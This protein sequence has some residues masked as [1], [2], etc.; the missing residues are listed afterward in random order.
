MGEISEYLKEKYMKNKG[1]NQKD[2]M[3]KQRVKNALLRSCE[4]H[5]LEP[6][7]KYTFEVLPNDL[8]YV[9]SSVMEEPIKSR[10]IITQISNTLF[11]AELQ[12]IDLGLW[13]RFMFYGNC[14]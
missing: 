4:E 5:V 12:E 1:S 3:N 7:D 10:Y 13:R 14:I 11:V 2:L 9:L 6:D 8:Q